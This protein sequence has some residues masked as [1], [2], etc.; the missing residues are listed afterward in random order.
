MYAIKDVEYFKLAHRL[1][2]DFKHIL[3][4]ENV[5]FRGSL[6]SLSMISTSNEKPELGVKCNA[7][8]KS[9]GDIENFIYEDI[10]KIKAKQFP[11]RNTPEKELQAWIINNALNDNEKKLAF[12][13]DI[14]FITSELA[15]FNSHGEKIVTDIL[16]YSVNDNQLCIIE[17]KSSRLMKELIQQVN[18]FEK[19]IKEKFDFFSEL[20][21]FQKFS[22]QKE[23][24]KEVKK[25]IVWPYARTSPKKELKGA[26]IIEVTYQER[27]TFTKF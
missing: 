18:N 11:K 1:N 23:L 10:R 4:K 19:V 14:K 20:L 15:I 17:L 5:H 25:I 2:E 3:L 8:Y 7:N 21:S 22:F 27:Y 9:T 26:N 16:G 6:N 12:D 13:K 24:S